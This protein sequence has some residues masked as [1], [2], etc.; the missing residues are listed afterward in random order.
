MRRLAA[1]LLLGA[2]TLVGCGGGPSYT[3]VPDGVL[4]INLDEYRLRPE[5]LQVPAG[6]IHV[7]AT[8]SGRLTHNLSKTTRVSLDVF[9]I[10]QQQIQAIDYH[11]ASRL[12]GQPGMAEDFLFHP[13]EPRGFRLR[14]RT[15]F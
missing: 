14:L 3:R 1:L 11:A 8:N 6:T 7:Q 15:T 12:W 13:A 2:T 9:N 5:N 10:F 4:K